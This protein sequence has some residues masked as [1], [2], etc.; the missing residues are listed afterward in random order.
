M[1]KL[2]LCVFVFLAGGSIQRCIADGGPRSERADGYDA[3]WTECLKKAFHKDYVYTSD[4]EVT[5]CRIG[6]T[7]V[8]SD[9][10]A[11]DDVKEPASDSDLSE[12]NSQISKFLGTEKKHFEKPDFAGVSHPHEIKKSKLSI[13]RTAPPAIIYQIKEAGGGDVF[14]MKVTFSQRAN[15]QLAICFTVISSD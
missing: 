3:V 4:S 10:M 7:F 5:Q 1:N 14:Y 6:G 9:S 11:L 13:S 8:T 2:L 15:G 12:F